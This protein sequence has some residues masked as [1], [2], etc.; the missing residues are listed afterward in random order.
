MLQGIGC[1]QILML[2]H[3][4]LQ[5][6]DFAEAAQIRL[7]IQLLRQMAVYGKNGDLGRFFIVDG[8]SLQIRHIGIILGVVFGR[9]DDGVKHG[10]PAV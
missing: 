10:S 5:H 6:L 9:A 4:M 3:Q 2:Q 1:L 8:D 7:Q